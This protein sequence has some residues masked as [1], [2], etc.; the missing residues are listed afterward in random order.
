MN[1]NCIAFGLKDHKN[2]KGQNNARYTCID[3]HHIFCYFTIQ[4]R[5]VDYN[6]YNVDTELRVEEAYRKPVRPSETSSPLENPFALQ[7][8]CR[9]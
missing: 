7:K 6:D 9:H 1:R 3:D 5:E 4:L 2:G 8:S